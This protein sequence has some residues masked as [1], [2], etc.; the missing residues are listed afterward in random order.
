M[1]AIVGA[2]ATSK[3][4]VDTQMLVPAFAK[5][6]QCWA[7]MPEVLATIV[8]VGLMEDA[9]VRAIRHL[10]PEGQLTVGYAVDVKHFSAT[11][12]GSRLSAS[13]GVVSVEGKRITF[14]IEC[15]DDHELVAKGSHTRIVVNR[16]EFL[17]RVAMKAPSGTT[18][19]L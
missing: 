9:C 15:R 10:L 12:L 17:R 1:N 18:R 13:A 14:S 16:A 3:L 7:E 4:V 8:V 11:P 19:Q 6:F 5:T 2:T